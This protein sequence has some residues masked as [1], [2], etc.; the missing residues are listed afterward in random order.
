MSWDRPYIF[1]HDAPQNIGVE[2]SLGRPMIFLLAPSSRFYGHHTTSFHVLSIRT[3]TY[4][5]RRCVTCFAN[6]LKR[7]QALHVWSYPVL[8]ED[9]SFATCL[10]SIPVTVK[11]EENLGIYSMRVMTILLAFM[12]HF[13]RQLAL[14]CISRVSNWTDLRCIPSSKPSCSIMQGY[15]RGFNSW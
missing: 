6:H 7:Y 11:K 9:E 13:I 10:W 4:T 12:E 14:W 15:R 1:D 8:S 5:Y 2:A 3:Y